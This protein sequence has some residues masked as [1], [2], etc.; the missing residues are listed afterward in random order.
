[1]SDVPTAIDVHVGEVLD[2]PCLWFGDLVGGPV[3]GGMALLSLSG[4][5]GIDGRIRLRNAAALGLVATASPEAVSGHVR[6]GLIGCQAWGASADDVPP[7]E[8]PQRPAPVRVAAPGHASYRVYLLLHAAV[9]PEVEIEAGTVFEQTSPNGVQ[10]LAT[11]APHR[12]TVH[13]GY[14]ASVVLDAWC[15]NRDLRPPH[16]QGVRITGLRLGTVYDSQS[17]VWEELAQW[18]G[19][20]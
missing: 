18:L 12:V 6:S 11:A 5:P 1:M 4:R 20:R 10:T 7:S 9:D 8:W 3:G 17:A 14:T 15:L 16:G 2:Q 19:Q 13:P